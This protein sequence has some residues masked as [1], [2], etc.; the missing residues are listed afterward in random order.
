MIDVARMLSNT[1]AGIAPASAPMFVLMQFVGG[2]V[3]VGVVA[4]LYPDVARV[5]EDVVVPHEPTG[6]RL[7]KAPA[8]QER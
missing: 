7:V 6:E 3:G 5:A 4:V 1:F 8:S 2:A